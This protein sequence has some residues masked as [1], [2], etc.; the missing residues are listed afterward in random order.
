MNI[1]S[2]HGFSKSSISTV[3][4]TCHSALVTYYLYKVFSVVKTEEVGIDNI[5]M[6]VKNK[7]NADNLYP[8]EI[9][10]IYKA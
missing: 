1:M 9:L 3:I 10:L 2:C 4:L 5:P 8:K 7:T 6:T